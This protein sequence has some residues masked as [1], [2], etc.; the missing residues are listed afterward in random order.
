MT[1]EQEAANLIKD[2]P[3]LRSAM[4][5]GSRHTCNPPPT[6]TDLDVLVYVRD[7]V[8]TYAHLIAAGFE[9]DGSEPSDRHDF[10]NDSAF[11]SYSRGEVNLIV[12][13]DEDFHLRFLAASSVAKRL[14]LLRKE[15]R[16]A[17]FQAVLYGNACEGL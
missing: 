13:D 9:H 7:L 4:L 6:G 3:G 11:R 2:V 1:P 16:V 5:V 15:D 8:P 10:D 12:T 17:L 14:N